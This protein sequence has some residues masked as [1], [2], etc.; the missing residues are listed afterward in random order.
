MNFSATRQSIR[1]SKL[2]L[3]FIS[4]RP[5]I[6]SPFEMESIGG[7]QEIWESANIEL[8]QPELLKYD[9]GNIK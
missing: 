9:D 3:W 5:K 8:H 6:I 1:S 7:F 2:V 4:A